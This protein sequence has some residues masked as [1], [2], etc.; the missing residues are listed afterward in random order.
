MS[1]GK[2]ERS[3]AHLE[4]W[5]AS[6][7]RLDDAALVIWCS[8]TG[9]KLFNRVKISLANTMMP[10]SGR[11]CL[12]LS[13]AAPFCFCGVAHYCSSSRRAR[14]VHTSHLQPQGCRFP[15]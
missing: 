5:K 1:P 8:G 3:F 6:Q 13:I 2:Q 7:R 14:A 4:G 11:F 9:A 10:A 12:A 15:A